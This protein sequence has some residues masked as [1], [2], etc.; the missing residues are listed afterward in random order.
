MPISPLVSVAAAIAA[1]QTS[2][3]LRVSRGAV[4]RSS[5]ARQNAALAIV[6]KHDSDMS[7]VISCPMNTYSSMLAAIAA[8]T[9]PRSASQARRPSR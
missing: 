5:C 6:R 8:P 4:S 1:Q 2:I 9:R 7:S 3:Q